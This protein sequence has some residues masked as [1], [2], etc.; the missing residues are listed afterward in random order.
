MIIFLLLLCF[1]NLETNAQLVVDTSLTATQLV[2]SVLSG[3]GISAFNITS[4]AGGTTACIGGFSN[5]NTTNLGLSAGVVIS[6]GLITNI[7]QAASQ[8]QSDSTGTGSDTLLDAIAGSATQDVATLEFDFI[9]NANIFLFRYVFGSEE[10]PEYVNSSYNDAIGFFISGPNPGGGNYTN[11]NL[12]MIPGTTIP[13]TINNVNAGSNPAYF[14][15]NQTLGG[16]T[17]VYDGFTTVLTATCLVTPCITYHIKLAVGDAGDGILDSGVF[18]EAGSFNCKGAFSI[19]ASSSNQAISDNAIENCSDVTVMFT[20]SEPHSIDT[21]INYTVSGTAINGV[22]YI[23]INPNQITIPAGSTTGSIIIHPVNDTLVEGSE[24]IRILAQVPPCG[25]D[26]IIVIIKDN[27]SVSADIISDGETGICAG[28]TVLLSTVTTGGIQP[29]SYNWSTGSADSSVYV[30]HQSFDTTVTYFVQLT[31]VCNNTATDSISL[32]VHNC[33]TCASGAGYDTSSCS[34]TC[35]TSPS[36]QAAYT[37]YYWTSPVSS[38]VFTDSSQAVTTVTVPAWGVYPLVWHVFNS[39][40]SACTDTVLISFSTIP[41]P[42]FTFTFNTAPDIGNCEG[43]A[44]ANVS[45]GLPP[46]AFLWNDPAG[47]TTQAATGLCTGTYT[48]TV[49]DAHNCSMSDT[50]FVDFGYI[51]INEVQIQQAIYPN[52]TTGMI[53]L[54]NIK[55]SEITISDFTGKVVLNEIVKN[56]LTEIG[57]LNFNSGIFFIKVVSDNTIFV[58]K[59]VLTE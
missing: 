56:G 7:P 58:E 27:S 2:Q 54:K 38:V 36:L 15:D 49:F 13:V 46:Y 47:Q 22:D 33:I 48:V 37:D 23:S 8:L 42:A 39:S 12:A 26:T 59:I 19:D 25:T 44:T 43:S 4:S 17:I 11:L 5:G 20:L 28:D 14:I 55:G 29:F 52:P 45:G 35:T 51:N 41:T 30:S 18:F 6:T 50:V 1:S 16:T 31:D 3:T 32:T 21:S 40:D 24:T 57:L 10:Y 53:Y 9:P 34:L